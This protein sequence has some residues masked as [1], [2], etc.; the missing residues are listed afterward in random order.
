MD[1]ND[2]DDLSPPQRVVVRTRWPN[3][4]LEDYWTWSFPIKKDGN[5]AKANARRSGRWAEAQLARL[6]DDTPN[7]PE[8]GDIRHLKTAQFSLNKEPV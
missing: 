6:R 2:Y 3:I 7:N 1:W 5:V 8:K 4:A